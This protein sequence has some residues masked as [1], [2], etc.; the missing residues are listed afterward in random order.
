MT[1]VIVESSELGYFQ[2]R[3]LDHIGVDH[4]D[5]NGD[6]GGHHVDLAVYLERVHDALWPVGRV[7]GLLVNERIHSQIGAALPILS[8]RVN[9]GGSDVGQVLAG[10][11]R[12]DFGPVV[13][14]A[15]IL[16]HEGDVGV[17]LG[18]QV[19]DRVV[20]LVACD[21]APPTDAQLNGGFGC[22]G[23]GGWGRSCGRLGCWC[24]RGCGLG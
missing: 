6:A 11:L 9:D 4:Q 24:R 8:Q 18:V 3:A 19:T 17:L 5:V 20:E 7:Y 15:G 13:G 14:P 21:V 12:G 16:T 2:A 10:S 23:H 22:G 1:C